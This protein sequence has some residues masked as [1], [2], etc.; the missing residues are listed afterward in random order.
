[1]HIEGST[2]T[3]RGPVRIEGSTGTWRD[4]VSY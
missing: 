4:L 1:M 2:G 3:L